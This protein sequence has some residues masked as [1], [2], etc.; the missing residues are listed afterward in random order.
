MSLNEYV[1]ENAALEWFGDLDYAVGQGERGLQ[2]A[3]AHANS[4]TLD[5]TKTCGS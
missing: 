5:D 3:S 2:A 4:R 1:A